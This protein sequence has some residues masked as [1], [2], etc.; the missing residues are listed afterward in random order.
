MFKEMKTRLPST[1]TEAEGR[2]LVFQVLASGAHSVE[3]L[4]TEPDDDWM[5]I[6]M[7][8]EAKGQARMITGNLHKH[9]MADRVAEIAKELGAVAVGFLSSAWAL[10]V[11]SAGGQE[12]LNELAD[13][14]ERTGQA[15]EEM[16]ERVEQVMISVHSASQIEVW[17]ADIKRHETRP[18]KLGPFVQ[19]EGGVVAGRM[20]DPLQRALI[21][22]G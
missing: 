21:R 17:C 20:S 10:N 9:E 16:A 1:K 18:P 4:F 19:F 15:I 8:V 12:Q 5:P 13:E 11:E 2:T 22:E 7:V 3:A 6:W 14:M